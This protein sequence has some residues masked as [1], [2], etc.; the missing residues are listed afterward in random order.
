MLRILKSFIAAVALIAMC[1]FD[2]SAKKN[3]EDTHV[4]VTFTD[5]SCID[6]YITSN[7][8]NYMKPNV[9]SVSISREFGGESQKYSS[10]EVASIVFPCV[11][12]DSVPVIYHSVMAQ[13]Q[14]SNLLKKNPKPY[15]K[16]IFLRLIYD[17]ANVKG[18]VMPILD[19]TNVPSQTIVNH[20]WRFF[21]KAADCEVAKAYWDA[22]DGIV[23][24]MRKV[25]KF[26][27][28]EFPDLQKMVD[29]KEVT[30]ADFRK[31]PAMVLPLMDMTYKKSDKK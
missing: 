16:P 19:V 21:Y 3:P 27:F 24:S 25:M 17:G 10:Q 14:I 29:R 23:P 1:T 22:T 28:R 9:S 13:K 18:Y 15:D 7:L 6:G 12:E 30:P 11:G 8:I 4:I 31:S 2:L 5:G 20:T 26:Y